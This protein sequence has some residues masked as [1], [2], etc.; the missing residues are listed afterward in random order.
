MFFNVSFHLFGCIV[1]IGL[2]RVHAFARDAG[3]LLIAQFIVVA[4]VER[5]ALLGGQCEQGI[6]KEGRCLIFLKRCIGPQFLGQSVSQR[7]DAMEQVR[8]PPE[9]LQGLVGRNPVEPGDQCAVTPIGTD[10]A[11]Y[12]D[13]RFLEDVL[14]IFMPNDNAADVPI[15]GA[16]ILAHEYSESFLTPQRVR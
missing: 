12:L 6:L 14:S 5:D 16:S 13:A 10:A 2:Q 3:N 9:V 11:Q 4:Q 8:F 15:N 7:V 1:I